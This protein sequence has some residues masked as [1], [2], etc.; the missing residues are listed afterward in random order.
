MIANLT[1]Y[2]N[3]QYLDVLPMGLIIHIPWIEKGVH[4]FQGMGGEL[5][6]S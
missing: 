3:L 1:V 4:R 2:G 6:L 5:V